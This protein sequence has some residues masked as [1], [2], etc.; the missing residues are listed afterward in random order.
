MGPEE[1]GKETLLLLC[2]LQRTPRVALFLK[3]VMDG[4]VDDDGCGGV[5]DDY[6]G[7]DVD[8]DGGDVDDD[9]GGVDD[10]GNIFLE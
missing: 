8:D 6:D 3:M 9:G 4:C 10:G 7:G 2:C 5:D 1:T